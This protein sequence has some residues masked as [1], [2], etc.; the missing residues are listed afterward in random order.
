MNADEW[1][2]VDVDDDIDNTSEIDEDTIDVA[3]D[4]I[5]DAEENDVS[6][7]DD[8]TDDNLIFN[9]ESDGDHD[10]DLQFSSLTLNDNHSSSIDHYE[11]LKGV[12]ELMKKVRIIIKFMR[13]HTI[14]SEYITKFIMSKTSDDKIGGLVLDMPIRWNSSFLLLDRLIALKDIINNMCSFPNNLTGLLDKQK[15]R[16]KELTIHKQEWE[17]LNALRH[18]LEPFLEATSALSAQ[19]YPT[20]SLSFRVF[21]LLSHFLESKPDDEPI[22]VALKETLRFWFNKHCK[23]NLPHG[24]MEI[25]IVIYFLVYL[26][27]IFKEKC[28]TLKKRMF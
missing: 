19:H 5:S 28:H 9:S 10:V 25:M 6:S 3:T 12:Y 15:K 2:D 7:D 21:H 13:N 23:T 14:T 26:L 18:V 11:L 17:L 22:T 4:L 27:I 24:Q 20:M 8:G 16:L 1:E